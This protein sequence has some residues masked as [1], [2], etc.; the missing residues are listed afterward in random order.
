MTE[1][2]VKSAIGGHHVLLEQGLNLRRFIAHHGWRLRNY[3]FHVLSI[4]RKEI[5]NRKI[6]GGKRNIYNTT[7][8]PTTS[9][10]KISNNTACGIR[11]STRE[12]LATPDLIAATAL[13]TLGI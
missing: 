8:V 11:P 9:S 6:R 3:F 10:V 13:S 1:H 4:K 2:N 5:F 7:S 12:T